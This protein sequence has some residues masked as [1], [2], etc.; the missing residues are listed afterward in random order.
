MEFTPEQITA[1]LE[2][3]GLPA[4]T[5]DAELVVATATDAFS[6]I[7]TPPPVSACGRDESDSAKDTLE[8]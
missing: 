3:L 6:V 7:L 1:L 2:A 5:A 8:E 4:D